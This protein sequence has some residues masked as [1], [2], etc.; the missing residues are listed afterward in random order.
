MAFK[1]AV[2][3]GQHHQ[4]ESLSNV[5]LYLVIAITGYPWPISTGCFKPFLQT[6]K[7]ISVPDLWIQSQRLPNHFVLHKLHSKKSLLVGFHKP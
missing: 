4:K 1:L 6:E 5:S 3:M 7:P 2:D